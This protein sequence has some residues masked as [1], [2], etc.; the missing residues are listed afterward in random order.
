MNVVVN[1][2]ADLLT[3]FAIRCSFFD[4]SAGKFCNFPALSPRARACVSEGLP[5][6]F[7]FIAD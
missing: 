1:I 3:E 6:M 5:I 4:D 2:S 7:P